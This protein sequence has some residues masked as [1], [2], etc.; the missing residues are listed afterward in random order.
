MWSA[1]TQTADMAHFKYCAQRSDL[2]AHRHD[3][4]MGERTAPMDIMAWNAD[5]TGCHECIRM[6]RA[7]FLDNDSPKA[8]IRRWPA[9][10]DSRYRA[11]M[12]AV[13]T[14]GSR[15]AVAIGSNFI[16]CR[17]RSN[18]RVDERRTAAGIIAGSERANVTG[19]RAVAATTATSILTW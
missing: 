6:R 4:L 14:E 17:I 11:P 19:L 5:A 1:A 16:C 8:A 10:R 7:L 18:V 2:V 15:R 12:F 13:L 9:G 3:Y